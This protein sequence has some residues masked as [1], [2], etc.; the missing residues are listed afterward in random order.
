MAS[1][2]ESQV[3]KRSPWNLLRKGYTESNLHFLLGA[4]S[5]SLSQLG[6]SA[7]WRRFVSV[8]RV[9]K[10]R[11]HRGAKNAANGSNTLLVYDG[12]VAATGPD[13]KHARLRQGRFVK[14]RYGGA[15]RMQ[16]GAL[17]VGKV[18]RWLQPQTLALLGEAVWIG[19]PARRS[20]LLAA[21]CNAAQLMSMRSNFC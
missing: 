15:V 11:R 10:N 19:V 9:L 8:V 20:Q 5:A 4:V 21:L 13:S 14:L 3:S 1:A 17:R 12:P 7:G 6:S 2:T 18:E 16:R